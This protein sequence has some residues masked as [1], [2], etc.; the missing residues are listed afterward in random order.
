MKSYAEVFIIG[1]KYLKIK[2]KT[3]EDSFINVIGIS[4]MAVFIICELIRSNDLDNNAEYTVGVI[5]EIIWGG[6]KNTEENLYEFYVNG[7]KY[8]GTETRGLTKIVVGDSALIKYDRNNPH[9]NEI[10]IYFEYT[11]DRSKLPDSVFYRRPMS[12]MRKPLE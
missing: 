7:E 11:L 6:G 12:R 2:M 10:A 8:L 5:C 9:N 4:I 1:L 3:D